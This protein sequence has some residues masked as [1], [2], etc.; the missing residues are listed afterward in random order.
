M[1]DLVRQMIGP[2]AALAIVGTLSGAPLASSLDRAT[3]AVP[4]QHAR[5]SLQGVVRFAGGGMPDLAIV[6]LTDRAGHIARTARLDARGAYS[7]RGVP[8]GRYELLA[9]GMGAQGAG[10][11]QADQ[12]AIRASRTATVDIVLIPVPLQD[13]EAAAPLAER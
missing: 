5:P 12:V 2:A 7:F 11:F 10:T 4:H 6:S 8:P 3:S 13:E 9:F 1:L